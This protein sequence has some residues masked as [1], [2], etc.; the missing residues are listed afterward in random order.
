[1]VCYFI[2]LKVLK[3]SSLFKMALLFLRRGDKCS[4]SRFV[5]TTMTFHLFFLLFSII[6]FYSL[7]FFLLREC[8]RKKLL[9]PLHL[10]GLNIRSHGLYLSGWQIYT[11][12]KYIH[13]ALQPVQRAFW[14]QKQSAILF[15]LFTLAQM[16]NYQSWN[17]IT[18]CIPCTYIRLYKILRCEI[19]ERNFFSICNKGKSKRKNSMVIFFSFFF[20]KTLYFVYNEYQTEP[21][22]TYLKA[23]I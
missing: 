7:T 19:I 14:R 6:N 1:M 12:N 15:I 8:L 13:N 10:L 23:G 2:G 4:R 16:T 9:K 20:S 5:K 3:I 22:Q 18:A 21:T 17:V 11:L